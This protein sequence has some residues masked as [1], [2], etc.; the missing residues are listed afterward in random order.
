MPEDPNACPIELLKKS[1]K[2]SRD[3]LKSKKSGPRKDPPPKSRRK[4]KPKDSEYNAVAIKPPYNDEHLQT[5]KDMC[6]KGATL[7]DCANHFNISINKMNQHCKRYYGYT[8]GQIYKQNITTL[9]MSVRQALYKKAIVD[10][11]W[12]AI[13]YL[14]NNYT[15]LRDNP[16][17]EPTIETSVV[18]ESEFG[19]SGEIVQ[20]VKKGAALD[21]IENFDPTDILL[22]HKTIDA[23]FEDEEEDVES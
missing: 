3:N 1:G 14:S 10:E 22:E 8:F 23:V 4:G 21:D 12:P 11:Y 16:E 20:N 17:P 6:A 7:E 5:I 18:Y 15:K 9:V 2:K 19:D 13:R